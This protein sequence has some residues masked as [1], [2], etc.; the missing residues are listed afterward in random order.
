MYIS[1]KIWN[2]QNI[3]ETTKN[4]KTD[5]KTVN[6]INNN[7]EKEGLKMGKAI[8]PPSNESNIKLILEENK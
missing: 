8:L 3:L 1:I 2:L 6:V 4:K 7:T 5:N